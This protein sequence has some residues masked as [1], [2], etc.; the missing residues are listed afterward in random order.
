[1]SKVKCFLWLN[2]WYLIFCLP[3]WQEHQFNICTWMEKFNLTYRTFVWKPCNFILWG[4][5]VFSTEFLTRSL[6]ELNDDILGLVYSDTNYSVVWLGKLFI[7]QYIECTRYIFTYKNNISTKYWVLVIKC[8]VGWHRWKG[9][10]TCKLTKFCSTPWFEWAFNKH[11]SFFT[12]DF[13]DFFLK[14]N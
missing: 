9:G 2:T 8:Y 1:M 5:Q 3:L 14:C 6:L 4:R 13:V 10:L 12:S 11:F 7:A